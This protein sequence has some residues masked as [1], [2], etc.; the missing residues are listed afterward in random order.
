MKVLYCILIL[1]CC[2]ACGG[3]GKHKTFSREM[4]DAL[5]RQVAL[6]D[7]VRNIVCIRASAIRLVTYAGG[8]DLICGVEEQESREQVFTHL[9]AH[10]GLRQK[11]VIGPSMGGDPELIMAAAPDVIFMSTTTAG[12]A[13]ALQQRTGI[14]VF[15]IEYG[16]IG[17]NRQTFYSS[18]RSIGEVLGTRQRVDSLIRYTDRQIGEL[19]RRAK[20]SGEVPRIYVGG[21]SYKGQKGIT[22]TDPYYAA[23][24]FLKAGNVAAGIDSA[25]VS[26]ITGTYI[27]W[28]QLADW[29]PQVIFVDTDGLPLVMEEFKARQGA[30][31]LLTAYREKRIYTLWP[32]NNHHTNFEVMLINA[33][34]AGKVLFPGQFSDIDADDKANEILAAFVGRPVADSLVRKWGR[35]R[36]VFAGDVPPAV[37]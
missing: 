16:D 27:D 9:F 32:Y 15:T 13:D 30:N 17:R 4:K 12:D 36:N 10:P 21:I 11:A 25:Y 20:T 22:S 31:R 23:F 5:G 8:A 37:Q 29:D 1:G 14:P 7:T 24:D 6:P 33:W 28:E 35:C 34:I 3:Q 2:C 19:T 18:L 26:P